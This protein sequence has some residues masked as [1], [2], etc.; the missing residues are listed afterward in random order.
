MH[1]TKDK[2]QSRVQLVILRPEC[3]T[4]IILVIVV[5]DK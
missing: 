5:L 4:G 3:N 2:A 1:H